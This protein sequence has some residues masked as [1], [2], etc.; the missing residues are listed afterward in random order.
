MRL[1]VHV[2]GETEE[3]FVNERLAPHLRDAGYSS[4]AARKIGS[5]RPR[6][7]RGGAR[8]WPSVQKG[9]LHHLRKDRGSIATTMVDYYAL[10]TGKSTQWPGRVEA[11]SKPFSAR[12]NTV[13]QAIGRTFATRWVTHSIQVGS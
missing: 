4:V 11:N 9:I 8:P 3:T 12:A 10:P 13:Q 1:L 6:K 2:E 5:A 7:K